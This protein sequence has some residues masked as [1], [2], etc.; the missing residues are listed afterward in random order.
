MCYSD[1]NLQLLSNLTCRYQSPRSVQGCG[2]IQQPRLCVQHRHTQDRQKIGTNSDVHISEAISSIC[3]PE[4]ASGK[5]GSSFKV[6]EISADDNY[7]S[8]KRQAFSYYLQLFNLQNTLPYTCR[9][10]S[11]IADFCLEHLRYITDIWIQK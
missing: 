5:T 2:A 3:A 9:L 7:N 10:F 1:C 11:S 6:L 8:S 4:D